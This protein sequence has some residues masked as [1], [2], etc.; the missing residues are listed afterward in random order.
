[1]KYTFYYVL[2]NEEIDN[3]VKQLQ[4]KNV[5]DAIIIIAEEFGFK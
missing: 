1:M 3:R 2:T 5:K 4:D